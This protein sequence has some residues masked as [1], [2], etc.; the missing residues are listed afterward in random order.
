MQSNRFTQ[1]LPVMALYLLGGCVV[2]DPPPTKRAAAPLEARSGSTVTGLA[3]FQQVG[4]QV[5]LILTVSGATPG[6]HAAHLHA[7][8]DCSAADAT[9]AMGHWNPGML[10]HA[11][12]TAPLHHMGDCGNFEVGAD[13]TGM[14]TLN[15]D[16]SIGTGAPN[17]VLGHSIIVHAAPDDGMTQM[18]PGNAGARVACG[19]VG[20]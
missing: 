20:L 5:S 4:A 3:T 2:G 16:W 17:D 12:P 8:P 9:S 11:L 10:D 15:A 6:T 18:P 13:G 1:L 19:I 7:V 14:L